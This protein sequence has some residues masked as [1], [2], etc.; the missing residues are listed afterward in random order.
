MTE[1]KQTLTPIDRVDAMI[2]NLVALDSAQYKKR[3][4]IFITIAAAIMVAF[5]I[6][7]LEQAMIG[8][9]IAIPGGFLLFLVIE[10][11]LVRKAVRANKTPLRFRYS[12][13][14]RRKITVVI[15]IFVLS[16]SIALTNL[17]PIVVNG[18]LFVA[19]VLPLMNFLRMTKEEQVLD[20]EG[21]PDPRDVRIEEIVE[22]QYEELP[23]DFYWL[24]DGVSEPSDN[25][26]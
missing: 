8:T 25:T 23:D 7:P 4:I 2:D 15:G 6:I 14:K 19:L 9:I 5:S 3:V 13:S 18:T 1:P 20:L 21:I 11:L 26:Q 22:E 10:S 12:T 16:A 17:V 24:D